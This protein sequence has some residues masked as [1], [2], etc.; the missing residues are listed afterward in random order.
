MNNWAYKNIKAVNAKWV[1]V[2]RR[3]EDRVWFA[4]WAA[5]KESASTAL[6]EFLDAPL[7]PEDMPE[8]SGDED[9]PPPYLSWPPYLEFLKKF[10]ER[11]H[12]E[13]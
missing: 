12:A 7:R 10:N 5:D 11:H 4:A 3:E 2:G 8:D 6:D 13:V 9:T 1:A